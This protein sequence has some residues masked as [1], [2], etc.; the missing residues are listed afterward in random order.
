MHNTTHADWS[1]HEKDDETYPNT[2]KEIME[3]LANTISMLVN[4]RSH[5]IQKGK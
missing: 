5:N 2:A 4:I 3:G 1:M